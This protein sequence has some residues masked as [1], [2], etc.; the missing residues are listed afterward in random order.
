MISRL[1]VILKEMDPALV[2]CIKTGNGSAAFEP[3]PDVSVDLYE[4]EKHLRRIG[5]SAPCTEENN[6]SFAT[7]L[8]WY[9]GDFKL[10]A[11]LKNAVTERQT[12]LLREDYCSVLYRYLQYL[13][14]KEDD[15]EIIYRCRRGLEIDRFDEK[16]HLML[17]E[18][19]L[20][21][22]SVSDAM[23]QY[24]HVSEMYYR[25][26]G[27]EPPA[28]IRD[29][30]H[31]IVTSEKSMEESLQ[32]LCGELQADSLKKGGAYLCDYAAFKEVYN[33][34]M[35]SVGR[36]DFKVFVLLVTLMQPDGSDV[37]PLL[38]DQS[39]G[40]LQQ[41]LRQT[42][43]SGDVIARYSASRFA[44]LLNM[45]QPDDSLIVMERVKKNFYRRVHR[46]DVVIH[47]CVSCIEKS[48]ENGHN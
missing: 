4:F 9:S 45:K 31:S 15:E 13:A 6:K 44:L 8:D 48:E 36:H 29:F 42:L 40:T 21:T 30:Y 43:R 41:V 34:M 47:Y 2:D 23:Q 39:M 46:S 20:R 1:R 27:I 24:R 38:L 17:M 12:R 5:R 33:L 28:G 11:D 35:R 37:E 32:A 19:M 25:Y 26:L 7:A 10:P 3:G 18:A 16:L 14:T 22:G